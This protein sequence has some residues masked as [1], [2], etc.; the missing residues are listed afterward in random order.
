MSNREETSGST[1]DT[2]E[3]LHLSAG[4]GTPR[5]PPRGAG[6]SGRGQ[7]PLVLVDDFAAPA[8]QISGRRWMDGCGLCLQG[9]KL[10]N[11]S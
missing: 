11:K 7:T 10:E 6:G 1:Q 5:Y 8:T 3:G 4:L 9:L 2:L